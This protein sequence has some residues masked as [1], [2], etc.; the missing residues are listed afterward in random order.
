M[1]I[2]EGKYTSAVVYSDT[3]EARQSIHSISI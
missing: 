2:I 1:K 3:I